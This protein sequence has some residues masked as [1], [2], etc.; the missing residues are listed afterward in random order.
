MTPRSSSLRSSAS[1]SGVAIVTVLAILVLVMGL[2]VA[3]LNLAKTERKSASVFL[4]SEGLRQLSDSAVGIVQA[5]IN[6][7]TTLGSQYAWASQPGMIR[8]YNSEAGTDSLF[9]TAYKLYS[10]STLT[11]TNLS[12]LTGGA[13]ATDYPSKDKWSA[14]PAL[15]TDLNAPVVTDGSANVFPIIDPNVKNSPLGV[16][17]GFDYSTVNTGTTSSAGNNPLPMPVRWLYVLQDG[18][19]V[20]PTAVGTQVVINGASKANPVKGR[21]AF[22]TDDESCKVNVNT[23]GAGASGT[24]TQVTGSNGYWDIPRYSIPE[25]YKL[26]T[27]QPLRGEFQRYP[28]HPATTTLNAVFPKL[29]PQRILSTVTPRYGWS[30]QSSQMGATDTV[31]TMTQALFSGTSPTNPFY[32]DIDEIVFTSTNSGR[33]QNPYFTRDTVEQARFFLSTNS[34]APEL[35]LWGL[36]R[37]ACWPV[38]SDILTSSS[39]SYLTPYDQLIARCASTGS[40]GSSS[41]KAYFF[42]RKN[43]LSSTEDANIGRNQTIFQYL[44]YLTNLSEPGYGGGSFS[45]KYDTDRDQILTEIWDYIRCTNLADPNLL[46]TAGKAFTADTND[47]TY[48]TGKVGTGYV[49]PLQVNGCQGFG[50]S[51][52]VTELA[53]VFICAGDPLDKVALAAV[54]GTTSSTGTTAGSGT[55][56]PV[57]AGTDGFLRSN[58]TSYNAALSGTLLQPNERLVQMMIIPKFFSPAMGNIHLVNP[59]VRVDISNLDTLTLA[60]KDLFPPK[61]TTVKGK[62]IISAQGSGGRRLDGKT[63]FRFNIG[64]HHRDLGGTYDYRA[65]VDGTGKYLSLTN[66]INGSDEALIHNVPFE[67]SDQ[68]QTYPFISTFV[69]VPITVG[70]TGSSSSYLASSNPGGMAFQSSGELTVT[71]TSLSDSKVLQTLHFAVPTSSTIPIPNLVYM[72]T[73]GTDGSSPTGGPTAPSTGAGCWWSFSNAG[74]ASKASMPTVTIDGNSVVT[75]DSCGRLA[76]LWAHPGWY[77]VSSTVSSVGIPKDVDSSTLC[78]TLIRGSLYGVSSSGNYNYTRDKGSFYYTDVV[79]SVGLNSG[80]GRLISAMNSVPLGAFS[81]INGWAY[82]PNNPTPTSMEHNLNSGYTLSFYVPGCAKYRRHFATTAMSG[83]DAY[84]GGGGKY[85]PNFRSDL[86][87]NI[88]N[89]LSQS[90]DFDTPTSYWPDGAYINKPD[91][92]NINTSGTSRA[93]PY[94]QND[95]ESAADATGYFSPNRMMPG[96]GMF[97]SLPTHVKRYTGSNAPN[98]AWKTLLFRNQPSHPEAVK[99]NS[100]G[101]LMSN[102]PDHLLMD[103]FWMPVVEPYAISESFAT[104]GKVNMN[105]QI[106][107]FTYIKRPTAMYAVLEREKLAAVSGTAF[108][109][110]KDSD[111][112]ATGGDASHNFKIHYNINPAETLRQFDGPIGRFTSGTMGGRL[113]VS[114]S[115]LCDLWLVPEGKTLEN[116]TGFWNDNKL[117]GD[118]IRE[119]PYTTI[120]PR[121]TTKSNTY[122]VHYRVQTLK[123]VPSG[124]STD[125]SWQTWDETKDQVTGEY[126]G[127]TTIQRFLDLNNSVFTSGGDFAFTA[128]TGSPTMD[129]Y[130]RWRVINSKQFAP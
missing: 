89:K 16:P 38:H 33:T 43:A 94:F 39:S 70:T 5:Q 27:S 129:M 59:K 2:V 113:F 78:G 18:Q 118:N 130:Y 12:E 67:K 105:Y 46:T 107:P 13:D 91:E 1:R 117:T 10:A 15:W 120:I 119:R 87:S 31:F 85:A 17:E 32:Q 90:L 92:G 34:Q 55:N 3:L 74:A 36:P 103:L 22:W 123:Q 115:E 52:T 68:K 108:P 50:R 71:I 53:F 98:C 121:L 97:G 81:P 122:T 126:R 25:D 64:W 20:A 41:F 44:Q 42:T 84:D 80:D 77:S 54:T 37:I 49:A 73:S 106:Q 9:A 24:S 56:T 93:I 48:P 110:Y 72:G 45:Q 75:S 128:D 76:R 65:F 96:P 29:E 111:Y 109:M 21:I 4:V 104:A 88:Y 124:R 79:R 40:M 47:V 19:I 6:T 14:A 112:Y 30:D 95:E 26:A 69:R 102:P 125:A 114:P 58:N 62:T 86:D 7:A 116:M 23:A 63:D 82:D 99:W 11:T 35:N 61:T 8:T 127:S 66:S 100:G 28:G 57:T 60:G 83:T 101:T 51:L